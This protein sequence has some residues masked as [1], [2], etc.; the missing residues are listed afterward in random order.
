M[1]VQPTNSSK[2]LEFHGIKLA[3]GATIA[4]FVVEK[5]AAAPATLEAGRNWYNTTTNKYEFV[6]YNGTELVVESVATAGELAGLVDA[7]KAD[8][9]STQA[10]KGTG[11]VGFV[12]QTGANGEFSVAA[13]TTE[14]TIKSIVNAADAEIK[15]RKDAV[16]ASKT[17][18]SA[19]LFLT[20]FG[21]GT[22]LQYNFYSPV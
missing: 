19:S 14:D 9:A 7:F 6:K 11:L 3:N 2:Y 5:L 17:E 8:L 20:Y 15:N 4:N 22:D 10:G 18:L 13:G 16:Q 12:G 1:S 21:F